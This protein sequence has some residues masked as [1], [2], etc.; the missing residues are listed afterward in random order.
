MTQPSAQRRPVRA[1]A[2]YA[3]WRARPAHRGH[4]TPPRGRIPSAT[5]F[6]ATAA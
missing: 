1:R 3:T 6:P 5:R 4:R 2:A